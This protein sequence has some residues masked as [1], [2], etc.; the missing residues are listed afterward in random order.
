MGKI[1]ERCAGIDVGKRFLFCCVL[2]GA[3][4]EEPHSQTI[5]FD[6][7]VPALERLREWL[8]TER[9]T[10]VAME[11]TGSYWI[12]IFNVLEDQVA[13]VLAKPVSL[14]KLENARS[15]APRTK[16]QRQIAG[17][18]S[19]SINCSCASGSPLP[20]HLARPFRIM[21]TASIP[22][23]DPRRNRDAPSS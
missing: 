6:A 11:S 15:P 8:H 16:S 5:R 10:H 1:I 13:I 7:T 20:T 18:N 2:T 12:P 3:A 17:P 23:A 9:V 14:R 4:N 22:K 19:S 21:W